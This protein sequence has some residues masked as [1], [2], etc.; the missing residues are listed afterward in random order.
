[1]QSSSA[2]LRS[3]AL[4]ICATALAGCVASRVSH[5]T[6]ANTA[7]VVSADIDRLTGAPW[8][9]TLTYLDYTSRTQTSISSSLLMTRLPEQSDGNVAWEMRVSYANEPHANRAETAV[10]GR[11]GSVFRKGQVMERSVLPDG[12][13]RVV[14]EQDGQDDDRDARFRFV[15]LLGD[16]QCSIQKLVRFKTEETFFERHIYR[17]SR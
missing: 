9:G 4:L 8:A 7:V 15:Y 16:K 17:W 6:S 10:L 3:L 12:T 1:M 2:M 11:G 5:N 13:V 14:T